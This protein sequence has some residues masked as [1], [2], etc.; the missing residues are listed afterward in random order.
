[1]FCLDFSVCLAIKSLCCVLLHIQASWSMNSG[2]SHF[3]STLWECR[4]YRCY[5][6]NP[7]P[8]PVTRV[9]G[10]LT[11]SGMAITRE[12]TSPVSVFKFQQYLLFLLKS[13]GSQHH[14]Q[15]YPQTKLCLDACGLSIKEQESL[16]LQASMGSGVSTGTMWT[17]SKTN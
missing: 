17:S 3:S 10:T 4:G 15:A 2:T 5:F 6:A 16:Q 9:L 7:R 8:H 13:N 1:M 12:A 14:V 11:Y